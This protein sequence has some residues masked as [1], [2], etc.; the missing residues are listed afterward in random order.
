[1]VHFGEGRGVFGVYVR[2]SVSRGG[3]GL[4]QML[5]KMGGGCLGVCVCGSVGL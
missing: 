1:M 3:C 5:V 2:T 4:W